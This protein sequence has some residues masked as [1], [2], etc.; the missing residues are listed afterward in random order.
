MNIAVKVHPYLPKTDAFDEQM[1]FAK[2]DIQ[3]L[4]QNGFNAI[5]LGIMWQGLQPEKDKFNDT[6]LQ[7]LGN[8]VNAA[9]DAGIYTLLE[10][11]QKVLSASFCGIGLPPWL[12][13]EDHRY[14]TFPFPIER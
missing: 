13:H 12:I 7:E 5:R 1:S 3:K 9:G 11:H 10:F 4:K 8:I 6:Y 2:E 14:K